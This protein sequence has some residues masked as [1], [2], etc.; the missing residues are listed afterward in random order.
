MITTTL[1]SFLSGDHWMIERRGV[2]Y[3]IHR[4][5]TMQGARNLP[6]ADGSSERHGSARHP[7]PGLPGSIRV[8]KFHLELSLAI[9]RGEEGR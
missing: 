2:G 4:S 9:V 7:R 8:T 5:F 6:G 1:R 3:T